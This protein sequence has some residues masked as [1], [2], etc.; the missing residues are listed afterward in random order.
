MGTSRNPGSDEQPKR[1]PGRP[2]ILS[3]D[4]RR[5]GIIFNILE[6]G[7]SR[8]DAAAAAAIDRTT[9]TDEARRDPA[10]AQQLIDAELAGKILA[11]KTIKGAIDGGDPKVA[12]QAAKWFLAVKYWKEFAQRNPDAIKP[13][14]VVAMIQ[15]LVEAV[16]N[17][18]PTKYHAAVHARVEGVLTGIRKRK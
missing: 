3:K 1:G 18:V 11:L 9:L 6:L 15:Q 16:L 8:T 12:F 7:G 5:K 2:R 17:E 10:F 4:A 13:D 14:D